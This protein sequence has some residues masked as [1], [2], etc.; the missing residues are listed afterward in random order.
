VIVRVRVGAD[1]HYIMHRKAN[2]FTA[3]T[4]DFNIWISKKEELKRLW[5]E[6]KYGKLTYRK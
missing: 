6:Q 3:K 4:G 2:Y 5:L 1:L